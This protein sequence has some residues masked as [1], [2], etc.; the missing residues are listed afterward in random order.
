[1]RIAVLSIKQLAPSQLR[2]TLRSSVKRDGSG[3]WIEKPASW[4]S[5]NDYDV[6]SDVA[7]ADFQAFDARINNWSK[8]TGDGLR[9]LE[10]DLFTLLET[11]PAGLVWAQLRRDSKASGVRLRSLLE[12]DGGLTAWPWEA[13]RDP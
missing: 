2:V 8:S 5:Q 3:Q 6:S 10:A 7:D 11:T 13:L 9:R 4:S 1:M 12:L